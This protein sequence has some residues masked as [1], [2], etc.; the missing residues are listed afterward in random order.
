[1]DV[2]EVILGKVYKRSREERPC[3]LPE[4]RESANDVIP[5]PCDHLCGKRSSDMM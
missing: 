1:M 4:R 5:T 3:P 2:Y